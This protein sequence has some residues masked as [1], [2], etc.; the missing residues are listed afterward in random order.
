MGC[1]TRPCPVKKEEKVSMGLPH[2]RKCADTARV[3][4]GLAVGAIG[5]LTSSPAEAHF[6]L[7]APA[8]W[9][10]QDSVGGPQKNG[11]C[12][13]APN[14]ALGDPVG[15]PTKVVTALQS[16]QTV[17]VSVAVTVGH[18]GWFRIALVEGP[19]SS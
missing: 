15:T 18:P 6:K 2:R 19:S 10:S 11:P 5:I 4:L 13:A 7:T 1:V 3:A 14:T 16:S 8:S 9:L 12:A 17:P